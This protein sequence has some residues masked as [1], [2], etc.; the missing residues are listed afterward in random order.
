LPASLGM[1]STLG[2]ERRHIGRSSSAMAARRSEVSRDAGYA[3]GF[4][5]LTAIHTT[6]AIGMGQTAIVPSR[7]LR[8]L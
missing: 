1:G 7:I 8:V 5:R 4:R 3:A 6:I 2:N